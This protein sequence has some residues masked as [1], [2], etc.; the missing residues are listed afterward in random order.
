[1]ERPY[2]DEVDKFI[3]AVK[4]DAVTK[5]VPGYF[6]WIHHDEQ[7]AP[8]DADE[9]IGGDVD[10]NNG[11]FFDADSDMLNCGGDDDEDNGDGRY[12]SVHSE[13]IEDLG[14][15]G[16]SD[17]DDLEEMLKHFKADILCASP[18]GAENLRAV[19]DAAKKNVYE[20]SKGCPTHWTLLRFV[21]E[22]LILKAKHG[23]SDSSF[24]DLLKLLA[25]LLLKPNFVP[26]NTYQTKKVISPLTMGVERIHACRSHCILYRGKYENLDKC[27]TC[28]ASR[29]KRNDIF[30]GD[31]EGSS[32]GKKRKRKGAPIPSKEDTCL[33]IDENKRRILP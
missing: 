15:G 27:S 18:K 1:M 5:K 7:E 32:N 29:Y 31:D 14:L 30:H 33:S 8:I 16:D 6:V 10:D 21:L 12:W 2:R 19:K 26:T 20:K 28:G 4:K 11:A 3:E 13:S 17:A 25:C 24:N 9:L 23:W 22:L